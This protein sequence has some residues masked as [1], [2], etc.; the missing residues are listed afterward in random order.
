MQVTDLQGVG[1][2]VPYDQLEPSTITEV[3]YRLLDTIVAL[4]GGA[5]SLPK[6]ELKAL[7]NTLDRVPETRPVYPSGL[8]TSLEMAGFLNAFL[9]RCADWGD[10]YRR[11][12]GIF[13]HPSDQVAAILALCDNPS[14]SGRRVIELTHLAY[15]FYAVLGECMPGLRQPWDYTSALSLTIPIVAATCY[16]A[17]P[18]RI[19]NALNLSAAGGAVLHQVRPGDITNLKSGATAYAVARGLWCYRVSD[20]IHA[21]NSMFDGKDGWYRVIAPLEGELTS[22]GSDAT[23]S[24]V[25]VKTYPCFQVGQAPVECAISL[26]EQV[27][28]RMEQI[29]RIVIH[30]S[31]V[32]APHIIRP[33]QGQYPLSQAEADHHL[34]YCLTTALQHGA[35]TPLHYSA[36]YL[37]AGVTRRLIDLTEVQ[38]LTADKAATLSDQRGACILEISLDNHTKVQESRPRAEGAFSG[39]DTI[40]RVKQLQ[41]VVEKKCRMLEAASG[42][43]LTPVARL[44]YELEN[45]DGCT[46]L[47]LI[48]ASLQ[49]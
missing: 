7:C 19:Q 1:L 6:D 30:V 32:D 13:G 33:N 17:S 8:K 48:Q 37:Q 27:M 39:L 3:K 15:Q 28:E 45:H 14:V 43:D 42:I 34:K 49:A 40:E 12:D 23:Y 16:S 24:P 20:A 2:Y 11:K 10:T 25:E 47:D 36:E 41:E 31:D 22:L 21:P 4:V 5:L 9:L 26:H 44:V 35:L 29:R 46:L 38:V 18:Q